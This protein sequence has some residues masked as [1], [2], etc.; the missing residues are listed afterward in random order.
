[1]QYHARY[2]K[3]KIILHNTST[4]SSCWLSV[5][6]GTVFGFVAPMLVII[7]VCDFYTT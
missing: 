5:E 1:M 7:L 2:P 6:E 4:L 3:K